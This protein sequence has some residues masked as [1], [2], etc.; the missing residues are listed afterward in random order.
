M[1][2]RVKRRNDGGEAGMTGCDNIT[3]AHKRTLSACISCMPCC[4]FC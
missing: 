2:F 4:N 3:I 1:D